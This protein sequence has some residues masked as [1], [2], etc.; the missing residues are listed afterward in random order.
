[1]ATFGIGQR[2][3]NNQDDS[4]PAYT[5]K[6]DHP[7]T[8]FFTPQTQKTVRNLVNSFLKGLATEESNEYYEKKFNK[9]KKKNTRLN[10]ELDG[11]KNEN[12][13][14]RKKLRELQE[15]IFTLESINTHLR[16]NLN[17]VLFLKTKYTC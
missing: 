16:E 10:E 3:K 4:G 11:F 12:T 13:E 15:K 14:L 1:M 2:M 5:P 8:E 6:R 7:V 9:K 17:E